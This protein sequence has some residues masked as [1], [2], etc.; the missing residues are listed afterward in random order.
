MGGALESSKSACFTS[1]DKYLAMK[2]WHDG[3]NGGTQFGKD[4]WNSSAG[5]H[6]DNDN[7]EESVRGIAG[8]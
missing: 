7:S 3:Y 5:N 4:A 2:A 8:R 1:E 6:D